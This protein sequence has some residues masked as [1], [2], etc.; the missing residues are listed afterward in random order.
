MEEFENDNKKELLGIKNK[1]AGML[2]KKG[3][4]RQTEDI[5]QQ[6]KHRRH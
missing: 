1:V 2:K 4:G 5:S 6:V 3:V